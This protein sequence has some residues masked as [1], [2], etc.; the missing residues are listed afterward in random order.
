MGTGRRGIAAPVLA[1]ALLL[2]SAGCEP[3]KPAPVRVMALVQTNQGVFAPKEISLETIGNI[4]SMEGTAAKLIGG[5]RIVLNFSDPLIGASGGSLTEDQIAQIFLKSKGAQPRAAY[6]EKNGVLWPSDFHTWNMVSLYYNFEQA[7]VYFRSTGLRTEDITKPTVYYTPYF[8]I[9][10]QSGPETQIRDNTLFSSPI[11][12]F[13]ILPFDELQKVPLAMNS[14]V[15][16]HEYSHWVLNKRVYE[17]RAFPAPLTAWG[18]TPQV[19]I[20]KALDEGLADFHAYGATCHTAAGC[21]TRWI[22]SSLGKGPADDR[23]IKVTRCLDASLANA[24]NTFDNNLYLQQGLEYR[25][26]T[27]I[28]ACLYKTSKNVPDSLDA[29]E[30]AVMASYSDPNGT[31]PGMQQILVGNLT[32]PGNVGLH[33]LLNAIMAHT[34]SQAIRTEMC[35]R[36][37]DQLK[38]NP[39]IMTDCPNTAIGGTDCPAL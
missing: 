10:E 20:L 18:G 17:G 26:G 29:I 16:F 37:I 33:T 22:E 32:T 14:G 25:L 38:I 19:N 11:K 39:A 27:I 28:A 35:N 23:D 15:I 12:S 2:V 9:A 31:S 7:F 36:F 34:P 6:V 21:D 24:T 8:A 13:A 4:V 30:Q 1:L 5:A 3:Q